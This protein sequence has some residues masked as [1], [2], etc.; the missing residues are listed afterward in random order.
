[1]V[2]RP[3]APYLGPSDSFVRDLPDTAVLVNFHDVFW[4]YVVYRSL[5]T[6][7]FVKGRLLQVKTVFD[8]K[9]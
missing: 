3:I 2:Y 8:R 1:M 9:S 4:L 6:L 7:R 5:T